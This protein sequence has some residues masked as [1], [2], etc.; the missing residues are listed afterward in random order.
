MNVTNEH[1]AMPE[2]ISPMPLGR[3]LV[4]ESRQR[5]SNSD[6]EAANGSDGFQ[7]IGIPIPNIDRNYLSKI[8]AGLEMLSAPS[9]MRHFYTVPSSTVLDVESIGS[10]TQQV[11]LSL[12]FK[13]Y[14]LEQS[15]SSFLQT[16]YM[17]ANGNNSPQ[18]ISSKYSPFST[19]ISSIRDSMLLTVVPEANDARKLEFWSPK[20]KFVRRLYNLLIKIFIRRWPIDPDEMKLSRVEL[21]LFFEFMKRKFKNMHYKTDR[22]QEIDIPD[23]TDIIMRVQAEKSAKRIEERKKFVYKLTLKKLKKE[24]YDSEMFKSHIHNK[25]HFY[26]YYFDELAVQKNLSIENFYDPLNQQSKDRVYRTLSNLYLALIFESHCF[27]HDFLLYMQ[28]ENFVADYQKSVDKK[29]EKLLLKWE[30]LLEK[31]TQESSVMRNI[32]EYF[33][34][35][36]QCKL[37]WTAE[38][39]THASRSFLK[40]TNPKN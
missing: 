9:I 7:K 11:V 16:N 32:T 23:I 31:E 40:F 33:T 37:P 20:I 2:S 22:V 21:R 14:Q 3:I 26:N 28:S 36:R 10:K 15:N 13:F 12:C 8:P 24:F 4:A 35:N 18:I 1:Q 29:I 34:F 27:K 25:E 19:D 38:E 30:E 17:T 39:I 5:V 6:N